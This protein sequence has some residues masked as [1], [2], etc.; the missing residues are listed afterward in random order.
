M[1]ATPDYIASEVGE[2]FE[3]VVQEV[4]PELEVTKGVWV[5]P[6]R[7]DDQPGWLAD[8]DQPG[9]A[10]VRAGRR[11]RAPGHLPPLLDR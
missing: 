8:Y 2:A 6:Q 9:L 5:V 1:E 11:E 10:G 7:R 4:R 3:L